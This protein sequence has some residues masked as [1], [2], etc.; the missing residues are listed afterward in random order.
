[1]E[2]FSGRC[3]CGALEVLFETAAAPAS[4]EPRA[5]QC[6]FCVRHG[7]RCV[8]DPNGRITLIVHGH[9]REQL[10][11]YRFGL[12][13]ADFLLCRTCGVYLGA[14]L[15]EGPSAWATLNIHTLA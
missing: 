15:S 4:L 5:C 8:S 10:V 1:M 2:T 12:R 14:L 6:S 7:A 3:H 9:D 13:T 11:R